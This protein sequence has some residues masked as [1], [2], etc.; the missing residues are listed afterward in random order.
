VDRIENIE[1][2]QASE[3]VIEIVFCVDERRAVL[4]LTRDGR[5]DKQECSSDPVPSGLGD[6][7]DRGIG[8][9]SVLPP[10][11]FC[12]DSPV[13][14]VDVP[15]LA[16]VGVTAVV[17]TRQALPGSQALL[18]DESGAA[19]WPGGDAFEAQALTAQAQTLLG[20][21][22]AATSGERT[23]PAP[24]WDGLRAAADGGDP[25]FTAHCNKADSLNGRVATTFDACVGTDTGDDVPASMATTAFPLT[26][27]RIEDHRMNPPATATH[28][29]LLVLG[30]VWIENTRGVEPTRAAKSCAEYLGWLMLNS[31]ASS[32]EMSRELMIAEGTRRSNVSRLR[33]WL[34]EMADGSLYI[35]DA[36]SGGVEVDPSVTSDWDLLLESLGGGVSSASDEALERALQL[37][38]GAP[39]VD[40]APNQWHWAE[41]WR[42]D[43]AATVRD[44]GAVLAQHALDR[45]DLDTAR[46]AASRGLAA[47][48]E[49]DLLMMIR[50]RTEYTAGNRAEVQRLTMHITRQARDLGIDLSD[51]MVELLQEVADPRHWRSNR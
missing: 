48:P 13:A 23:E 10:A 24:W 4:D 41:E 33:N 43:M 26:N 34:G 7:T 39:L 51:E 1:N 19:R 30:P 20:G 21:I 29:R 3:A 17:P 16:G 31:G 46:W 8:T 44:V 25:F 9:P 28:P 5:D 36:Y 37:L 27:E 50:I 11:V 49:D 32:V 6:V 14:D 35:P 42:V 22:V 45:H 18:V 15:A 38:R 2:E 12:F 47:A 40:A